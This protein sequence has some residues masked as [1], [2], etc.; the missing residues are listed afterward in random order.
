[1]KLLAAIIVLLYLNDGVFAQSYFEPLD[2]EGSYLSFGV[3]VQ[4]NGLKQAFTA[5]G[6]DSDDRASG[7]N[8]NFAFEEYGDGS[9]WMKLDGSLLFL[10]VISALSDHQGM[11][12]KAYN[13]GKQ[14]NEYRYYFLNDKF[15]HG[16]AS[17]G[18]GGSTFG[19]V[20]GFGWEG[21]GIIRVLG[22]K[23][24]SL[25]DAI[26]E[27]NAGLLSMGTGLNWVAPFGFA[28]EHSRLTFTYDWFLNRKSDEKFWFGGAARGR[29]GLEYS[30]VVARRLTLH[31]AF[32]YFNFKNAYALQDVQT[33]QITY[34]D[35]KITSFEIGFAYNLMAN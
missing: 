33:G 35:A 4:A 9:G 21:V 31:T 7:L 34:K 10:A 16:S 18:V 28:G 24:G 20:I 30:V 11:P 27:G 26:G 17:W 32:R 12:L 6:V 13:S 8:A 19:P 14:E 15:F 1:M 3:G 23:G 2:G 25:D 5:S 22:K 29:F